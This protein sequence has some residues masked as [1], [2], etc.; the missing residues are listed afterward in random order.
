LTGNPAA[1]G[2][3]YRIATDDAGEIDPQFGH[4]HGGEMIVRVDEAGQAHA[5]PEV[6]EFGCGVDEL[7]G[8]FAGAD[9]HQIPPADD[10][11][12]RPGLGGVTGPDRAVGHQ[13]RTSHGWHGI[14]AGY[15][16]HRVQT[17]T[18]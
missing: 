9:V 11:R 17:V 8:G 2:T 3:Q 5:T 7:A 6:D 1:H 4:R 14:A 13:I 16:A 10:Y 12:L 15:G 18:P